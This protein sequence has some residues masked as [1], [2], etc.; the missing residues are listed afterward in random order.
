MLPLNPPILHLFKQLHPLVPSAP[1]LVNLLNS[2]QRL[3]DQV[4]IV[5][6]WP[7]ALSLKL[8]RG[9]VNKLLA[10]Q[11]PIR[12]SP[13]YFSWISF[14]FEVLVTLGAAEPKDVSIVADELNTMAWINRAGAKP[15]F[16][17]PHTYHNDEN[18]LKYML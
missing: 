1:Y 9:V 15:A 7:V 2:H 11:L 4:P 17:Q 5:L 13:L 12:F 14:H 18:K 10:S 8:K 3:L 6:D 16:K